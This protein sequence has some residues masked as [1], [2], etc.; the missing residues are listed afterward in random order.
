[1]V[2]VLVMLAGSV[3]VAVFRQVNVYYQGKSVTF[4][5]LSRTDKARRPRLL[6]NLDP[7]ARSPQR[8]LLD[9]L[10]QVVS[11]GGLNGDVRG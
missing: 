7:L 3:T 8:K 2:N 1:M 11:E 5:A 6:G 4:A 9:N 10:L